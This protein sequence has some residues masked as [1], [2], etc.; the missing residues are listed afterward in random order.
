MTSASGITPPLVESSPSKPRMR[1]T[2]RW[3]IVGAGNIANTFARD[4]THVAHAEVAAVAARSLASASEFAKR[5][6]ISVAYEGYETLYSDPN[7]DA[8]YI[9]TPHVLHACN[10]ADALRAG[11]AVMCEKPI[12]VSA[13]ELKTLLGVAR[14]Q[15]NYLM[16]AMWTWFLP[17][18]QK[19][20]KWIADG[21]IGE[22]IHVKA[23]FGFPMTYDP[24][25]RA[26]NPELAGGCL[27][28]TGIYPIAI[29]RLFT[30]RAPT[31]IDVVARYAPNGVDDD[32]VMTFDYGNCVASL[33][34]SFR[35]KLPN[36]AYLIGTAGFIAIPD[37]W[38]AEECYL[39]RQDESV[40]SFRDSRSGSGFEFQIASA[41]EDILQ[42][43]RQSAIVPH[44]ASLA[45]QQDMDRVRSQFAS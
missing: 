17:A 44:S 25:S 10:A 37:F 28:D 7:V 1:G 34:T 42:G 26:Y 14:D 18:F 35:R 36:I 5:H 24:A 6:Q 40:R 12:T 43:R 23:D 30:N 21:E 29:A 32:V 38:R 9:A 45:F 15:G 4:M 41:S 39:H 8:V 2:V 3:G 11:K 16:E 31:T 33:A 27:L 19:A 13:A 20:Q 22:L